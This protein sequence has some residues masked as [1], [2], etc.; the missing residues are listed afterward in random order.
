MGP[1]GIPVVDESKCTSCKACV[2]ICPRVLYEIR[3]KGIDGKRVYV[4][5]SNEQKGAIA[6]KNCKVAC[7]GCMKC[8][9]VSELV[10][11]ENNLSYIPAEVDAA[12]YGEELAKA[13]PTKAIIY[14]GEGS[15]VRA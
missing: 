4:A 2:N 13:C 12:Q 7:I 8:V 11:V 15:D 10:K 3:P 6:R 5:C 9:K 1:E 14:T